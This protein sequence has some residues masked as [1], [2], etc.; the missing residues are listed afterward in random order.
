MRCPAGDGELYIHTTTNAQ[1]LTLHYGQCPACRGLWMSGFD[2]NYI[3]S[4]I[5]AEK[6][7]ASDFSHDHPPTCPICQVILT[8]SHQDSIPPD[9]T[10]YQCESGHG[11]FFP[12]GEF[13]RFKTGQTTKI[14]YFKL[15]QIPF[16]SPTATL[17]TILVGFLLTAGLIAGIIGSQQAQVTTSKATGF[18]LS[19]KAYLDDHA[20]TI[21]VLTQ[22]KTLLTIHIAGYT[23]FQSPLQTTDGTSHTIR[24][25]NLV[26][27]SYTYYL[28]FQKD[29]K[30]L[31][32][33]NF[34]FFIQ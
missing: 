31:R 13:T 17:L 30:T 32:S 21:V 23:N 5:V 12:P 33:E 34:S 14:N 10:M 2:S 9:V 19:Q 7:L 22:Q 28:T 6:I 20:V 8:I 26:R 16:G 24:L 29:G 4:D 15:W 18:I 25:T 27:G 11:Y 3:S 1:S